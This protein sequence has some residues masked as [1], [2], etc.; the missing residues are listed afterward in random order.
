ME[1]NTETLSGSKKP[2][3]A[4]IVVLLMIL[5]ALIVFRLTVLSSCDCKKAKPPTNNVPAMNV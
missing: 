5:G 2:S 4:L 3:K 1:P